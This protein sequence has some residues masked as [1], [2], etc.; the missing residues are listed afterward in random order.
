MQ[1]QAY[2]PTYHVY[3]RCIACQLCYDAHCHSLDPPN[4]HLA[5]HPTLLGNLYMSLL[6]HMPLSLVV[7]MT[8]VVA[9]CI[10]AAGLY[11]T[12]RWC[13]R[14]VLDPCRLAIHTPVRDYYCVSLLLYPWLSNVVG[15]AKVPKTGTLAVSV[16]TVCSCAWLVRLYVL[17]LG[18][19]LARGMC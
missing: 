17:P 4:M 9:R 2:P 5:S 6:L 16:Y 1:R 7:C 12:W 19:L 13:E 11:L 10:L 3:L 18:L 15:M 8:S 14:D